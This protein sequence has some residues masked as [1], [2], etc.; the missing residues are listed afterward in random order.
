M[1]SGR[2]GR[3]GGR[4]LLLLPAVAC[5]MFASCLCRPPHH[6]HL[7]GVAKGAAQRI[8]ALCLLSSRPEASRGTSVAPLSFVSKY[9]VVLNVNRYLYEMS[10]LSFDRHEL[11]VALAGGYG[12][13]HATVI[14]RR[15][16]N[17]N[18]THHCKRTA[19]CRLLE[20]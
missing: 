19:I 15:R 4:L 11:Y 17:S 9:G 5:T 1:S 12:V 20:A 6:I 8:L 10:L 14:L 3:F 13:T 7:I 2:P 18:T 16:C